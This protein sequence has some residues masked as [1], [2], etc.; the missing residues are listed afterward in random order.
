MKA[1]VQRVKN[2][3]VLIDGDIHSAIGKGLNV[4]LGIGEG[5]SEKDAGYLADKIMKLRIF[6]DCNGKM[7]LSVQDIGGEIIVISQ[8]TLHGDCTKGNRPSFSK[9]AP[10][11]KAER[12]Y[13]YFIEYIGNKYG[14]DVKTGRFGAMMDVHIEN[15]G[16]VTLIM[17]SPE[18]Q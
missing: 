2:S 5:D 3:R 10:P 14:I 13:E 8:F 16:P 4:L 1:V 18:G 17:E 12:L 9:S 15:D 11:E 6:S 7:N